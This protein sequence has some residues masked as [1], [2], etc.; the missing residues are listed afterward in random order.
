MTDINMRNRQNNISLSVII[1]ARNEALNIVD[2]ISS[3][4]F[5]DEIL[6]IENNSTDKTVELATA[7]GAKVIKRNLDGDYSAQRNFAIDMAQNDWIFM[8]DADERIT[9]LLKEEIIEAVTKNENRCYQ[10]SRENHFVDGKVLHGDL[11]PDHVERLF[12]KGY[13]HY[14]G[15]IH[16]RLHTTSEIVRLRGRLIHFPYR[17]WEIH[18]QKINTYSSMVAEKY[19]KNGKKCSFCVD[20]LIK[21]LWAFFKVY[22]IH[23]GFLD[24]K[25][26]LEFCILHYFY[27][28]EKYLKLDSLNRKNG[29]I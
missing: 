10:V 20:I 11:R 26:G 22:F 8:L 2:C 16:E 12:K 13:A 21:P 29:R 23:R 19:H 7:H 15:L 24:G 25:L 6:V 17:S 5:A 28:I 18:L 3:A 27:T 1:L 9:P 14:E 4:S